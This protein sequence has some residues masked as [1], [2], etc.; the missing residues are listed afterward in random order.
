MAEVMVHVDGHGSGEGAEIS[1]SGAEAVG[2]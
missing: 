2:R 1:I